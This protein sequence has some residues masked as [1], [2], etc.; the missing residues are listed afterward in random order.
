[1]TGWKICILFLLILLIYIP[2]AYGCTTFVVTG[3]ASEDGSVFVGHSNDGFGSGLIYN[4]IREDMV[5]FRHVPAKDHPEKATRPVVYDPNSGGEFIGEAPSNDTQTLVL[6]EI[7][8]VNHTYAYITGS[9]GMI[10]E[11]QLMTGECTDYAK[12][13][14][15]AEKGKR[16]FYSSELSNI[17]LERCTK[18][19]DAVLLMGNLIET[20]GYYGTGET[21]I[22]ADPSDAWVIEMCGGTP[23]GT[24]GYWAAEQIQQGEIFVAANEFRIRE[25]SADNPSQ[26][27]SENL[28]KDAEKMGWWNRTDGTLD[29]TKTFGIGE[30]SHPYYSQA[31]VWRIFDRLAPSLGLSPYVEGPF[32]KAY[33]FSIKPDK[34]V[35]ITTALSIY[36]DHY[37]GTV[38]DLTAPPAGGPF[39]D[40]YR[41]WGQFDLH[42]APYEGE[43]KPGSWSR[44]ISTDPCGYSYICQGRST[45]P[46]PI[47][48]VCW[49]GL[50][51]PSETCYVPFYAGIYHLPLPYVHGSHW[52]FDLNTAFWPYELLQNY[53][54]LMYSYISPE[55]KAEQERIEGAAIAK[56]SDIEAE[57][58]ER[59]K[60]NE[61]SSR[62]YLTAYT[63]ETAMNALH[64]WKALMGRMIVTY[65][66]GNYN[67]V[68]N[69]TIS[70]I[71]YTAWWNEYARYQY[72]PRVYDM[73]GLNETPGVRYVGKVANITGNPV[74][75]IRDHQT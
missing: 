27:Y 45:L 32:S 72:G 43:L 14:P 35:N 74:T 21:L 7:P 39:G 48:G 46:D 73:E 38:F 40:P 69:H 51:S 9:Y 12:I 29:W 71:G 4:R 18:A 50:S 59:Y 17:A 31:R 15:G 68:Q 6:G 54:R 24:G 63:N 57:A 13:H 23:D 67:D 58:L 70:N 62:E 30:Y 64:D 20:Y 56:Q 8:E 34:P 11:H 19:K 2:S 5:S 33:P 75:Y 36:R 10:N 37:E 61:R 22:F 41:V 3:N 16:I 44:P 60:V 47:G 66:N 42:D 28:D 55:I 1:M 65:R 52:E 25:L 49:L 26:I 53:A